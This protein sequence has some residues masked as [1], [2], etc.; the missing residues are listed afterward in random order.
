MSLRQTSTREEGEEREREKGVGLPAY[1]CPCLPVSVCLHGGEHLKIATT[2]PPG[3]VGR[4]SGVLW[5][6]SLKRMSGRG[7][8]EG[9]GEWCQPERHAGQARGALVGEEVVAKV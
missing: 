4:T 2:L 5:V 9:G 3:V 8:E 1:L 7:N 6:G